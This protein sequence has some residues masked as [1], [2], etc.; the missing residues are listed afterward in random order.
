MLER[1]LNFCRGPCPIGPRPCARTYAWSSSHISSHCAL[2]SSN[3]LLYHF[4]RAGYC[5]C[6]AAQCGRLLG[7]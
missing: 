2:S 7:A 6:A 5:S 4:S 3:S 1:L